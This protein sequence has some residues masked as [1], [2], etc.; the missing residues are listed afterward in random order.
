MEPRFIIFVETV[1]GE[2]IK[3]FTWCRD[4]TSGIDRARKD[5]ESFGVTPVKI[6]AEEITQ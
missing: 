6:W 1:T 3:A 2:I 5:A 4:M